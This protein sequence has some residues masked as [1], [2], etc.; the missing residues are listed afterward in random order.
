MNNSIVGTIVELNKYPTDKYNVL[1]P[2]STMQAMSNLQKIIVNQVQLDADPKTSKDI[3]FERST[4]KYAITKVGGMKLAA[5]ANISIVDTQTGMT[6]A[7]KR[8]VDM[9]RVTGQSKTCGACPAR[10]DIACSV[11]IRVPEP[12]GGFRTITESKEIDCAIE[13]AGMKD[14]AEGQQFK[15]FLPHRAAIAESKAFMRALRAAL[16]LAGTYSL[17]EI[18]KPFI[19]AHVVPNLD[20]PEIKEAVASNYLQSMGMLFEGAAS[21]N[22]LPDVSESHPAEAEGN[23]QEDVEYGDYTDV[24]EPEDYPVDDAIYCDDCGEEIRESRSRTGKIWTPETIRSYSIKHFGRCICPRC[25]Q[26][27]RGR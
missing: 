1:I 7:C 25:Q 23:V 13:A 4:G 26:S 15:R 11:T 10:N 5:A 2:V 9:A 27:E 19:I 24:P 18:R 22:T 16:G 20:A 6:S 21:K 8:C 12:S 14:G 17:E 3:Y